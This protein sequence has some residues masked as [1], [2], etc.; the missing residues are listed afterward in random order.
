[1]TLNGTIESENLVLAGATLSGAGSVN[2][3]FTWNRGSL[4]PDVSFNV[5][6]AG[7]LLLAVRLAPLLSVTRTPT[8]TVV[9]SWPGPEAGWKLQATTSLSPTPVVWAPLP[10]PY[11]SC[12][13]NLCFIEAAP[14]ANKFYRLHK[15]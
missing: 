10:P 2:G 6:P 11:Q 9:V 14:A 8:N 4:T 15:P 12:G 1:M 3:S 7:Q 13:T 5:T